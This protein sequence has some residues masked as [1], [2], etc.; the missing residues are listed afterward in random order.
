MRQDPMGQGK[1]TVLDKP[2]AGSIG[3]RAW[4]ALQGYRIPAT[5]RS[6][7]VF[8]TLLD[9][10]NP[11]LEQRFRHLQTNNQALNAEQVEVLYRSCIDGLSETAAAAVASGADDLA[12]AAQGIVEQVAR[13]G[14]ALRV[15][16]DA[17]DHWRRRLTA[18]TGVEDLLR[19]V[20]ALTAE[21][22]RASARNRA[23]ESRLSVEADR[24]SRLREDLV[25]VRQEASTDALTGIPNRRAFDV[26]LRRAVGNAAA[27]PSAPFALLM[28]D[29][30]HFKRFNDEHGHKTGDQV[31]RL[32]ARLIADNVKGRDTAARFG[33][34]EFAVL[35]AG[36]D[37]TAAMTVAR[38]MCERLAGQ[39]LVKRGTG[40]S[41]GQITMSIGVA[42]F[43]PGEKGTTL[44]ERADAALYEAK[45]TGRNRVCC[46]AG[47][48]TPAP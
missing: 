30:D 31:L 12:D 18:E 13:G 41:V 43:E 21:T 8:Y 22:E 23:L 35:L 47:A 40:H 10:S 1:E 16:G 19:A 14:E 48:L 26:K 37:L 20:A 38:Q 11:E 28:L 15:Y 24:V 4:G 3:E 46:A 36:A 45:R 25:Q 32:V 34:E 5:P 39:R 7:Q 9:G 42:A 17:L 2:V 29:V 44:I 6:F 27:D 33:G